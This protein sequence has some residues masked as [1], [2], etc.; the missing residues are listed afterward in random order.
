MRK[1][2]IYVYIYVSDFSFCISFKLNLIKF[3]EYKE[4]KVFFCECY[5]INI[6]R[7]FMILLYIFTQPIQLIM[8]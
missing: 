5:I 4:N 1:N 3:K 6:L 2:N 7:I 8:L